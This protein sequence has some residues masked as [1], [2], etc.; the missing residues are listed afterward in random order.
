M[1]ALGL[2]DFRLG[3]VGFGLVGLGLVGFGLGIQSKC[4]RGVVE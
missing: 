4:L 2:I 3:L 1:Q